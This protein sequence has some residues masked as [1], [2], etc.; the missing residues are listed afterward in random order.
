MNEP[1]YTYPNITIRPH[2]GEY[3]IENLPLLVI[4]PCGVAVLVAYTFPFKWA[5]ELLLLLLTLYLIYRH[6]YL[7]RIKFH[8]GSEQVMIQHGIFELRRNYL[9]LYRVIDYDERQTVAERFFGI[10]TVSI[11]SGDRSTPRL[12]IIGV[13]ADLDLV[14]AIRERVEYNKRRKGVYELSNR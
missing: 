5:L 8:I 2:W 1:T 3:V 11:Y 4:V 7:T 14:V 12:D 6:Q 13:P 9:E 10:K